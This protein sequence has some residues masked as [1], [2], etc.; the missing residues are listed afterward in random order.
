MAESYYF[1]NKFGVKMA[2]FTFRY[3]Y[4]PKSA[5]TVW[6]AFSS[7]VN[8]ASTGEGRSGAAMRGEE[9]MKKWYRH[10]RVEYESA[11]RKNYALFGFARLLVS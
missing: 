1:I 11:V 9:E 3:R 7:D 8:N 4:I 10:E 5:Q 2:R 6:H